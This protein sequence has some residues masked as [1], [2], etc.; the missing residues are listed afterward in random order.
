M[1]SFF[2]FSQTNINFA[3]NTINIMKSFKLILR[4]CKVGSRVA[5]TSSTGTIEGRV[6]EID[7]KEIALETEMGGVCMATCEDVVSLKI[8]PDASAIDIPQT[9]DTSV[10]NVNM[11][12]PVPQSTPATED[13]PA[14]KPEIPN[15]TENI[16]NNSAKAKEED[17]IPAPKLEIPNEAE[18]IVNNS[19][20]A[21]EEDIVKTSSPRKT[22]P[23][24]QLIEM[25]WK[26]IKWREQ[27]Y[28]KLHTYFKS[29]GNYAL[30]E[31]NKKAL[32]PRGKV[33]SSKTSIIYSLQT[34]NKHIYNI[35]DVLV[36]SL[37]GNQLVYFE[38]K[39]SKLTDIIPTY[40]IAFIIDKIKDR[41]IRQSFG[42][43]PPL[44][45]LHLLEI[46]LTNFPDNQT[47]ASLLD[48][49]RKVLNSLSIEKVQPK[50]KA[51]S[52]VSTKGIKSPQ[53]PLLA[54]DG[55]SPS[56]EKARRANGTKQHELALKYCLETLHSGYYPL[57][58][59]NM[60]ALT[61]AT[62]YK[63]ARQ[64]EP[65]RA[66]E[67]QREAISFMHEF[68]TKLPEETKTWY[69]QENFY[70]AV[71]AFEDF[72]KVLDKLMPAMKGDSIKLTDYLNKKAAAHIERIEYDLA[73]KAIDESFSV[74]PENLGAKKLKDVLE[75]LVSLNKALENVKNEEEK[76]EI[77]EKIA[78]ISGAD[79]SALAESGMGV[80][81]TQVLEEYTE[82][83]GLSAKDKQLSTKEFDRATL[84]S[85]KGYM[86][87]TGRN[88]P[89]LLAKQIL[90][91][92]KVLQVLLA[93]GL[94][95][96]ETEVTVQGEM[97]R[98]CC[99]MAELKLNTS[100]N[101]DVVHFYYN[102]AFMLGLR[103]ARDRFVSAYLQTLVRQPQ[104]IIGRLMKM[105]TEPIDDLLEEALV[106]EGTKVQANW[107]KVLELMLYNK[108]LTKDIVER[109]YANANV[110]NYAIQELKTYGMATDEND[111]FDEFKRQ[112]EQQREKRLN[113]LNSL[114]TQIGQSGKNFNNI[115][116]ISSHLE[117]QLKDWMKISWMQDSL[118]RI[119]IGQILDNV[120][121]QVNTFRTSRGYIPKEN[122]Y[123][124]VR[125][126]LDRLIDDIKE[127]PTKLSFE[128]LIPLLKI[129]R[130]LADNAWS[131]IQ[132]TSEPKL[133]IALLSGNTVIDDDNVVALQVSVAND[134]T[135]SPINNVTVR[136]EN[137]NGV[138]FL[139][140]T[141]KEE[142]VMIEGGK[143]HIFRLKVKVSDE[144][145]RNEGTML[146]I[147]CEY[148]DRKGEIVKNPPYSTQLALYSTEDFVKVTDKIYF[149]GDA[150]ASDDET[151]VGREDYMNDIICDIEN[152][153]HKKPVQYI[154]YGQKR[155]GKSSVWERLADRLEK[156]GFF[157]IKFSLQLMQNITEFTFYRTILI[158]LETSLRVLRRNDKDTPNSRLPLMKNL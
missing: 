47:V 71:R 91:E 141:T 96:Q 156:D 9:E 19:A 26:N 157:C 126:Q 121:K 145:R 41:F 149:S 95:I 105:Q 21:K 129:I 138:T 122:A 144:V 68:G 4:L 54:K 153:N 116:D 74:T 102:Q 66:E 70:Y 118:D 25:Q 3:K 10:P 117:P 140:L 30:L 89:D 44:K 152:P 67:L 61:Y 40:K 99:T 133:T 82:M 85:I 78:E 83:E 39:D 75:K 24:D 86:T 100:T 146:T 127:N 15:E 73:K 154:I 50:Q 106:G 114:I 55:Y 62:L 18:N 147:L 108:E 155:C 88:R 28:H 63:K 56:W 132:N 87:R 103:E 84:N 125:S 113:E 111:S 93:Q 38:V 107:D 128:A 64:N 2:F 98:Y 43:T 57:Q 27:V 97:A 42:G 151:F 76:K 48:E 51:L 77:K 135:S 79:Y 120:V 37:T 17:N 101:L 60:T 130:E 23:M 29:I 6:L 7:E 109:L 137:A 65:E 81:I 90:T 14:S 13:I 112:W 58:C 69:M 136:T 110:R 22:I 142:G 148:A 5:L 119:R 115:G 45:E 35:S 143:Q 72:L 104:E 49:M 34:G 52:D 131:D 123:H 80:F 36:G 46:L 150:L 20:K 8:I 124:N 59:I 32:P 31:E 11:G 16:V 94:D 33:D 158:Q 92:V 12:I 139:G 134:E 1:A 53:Q